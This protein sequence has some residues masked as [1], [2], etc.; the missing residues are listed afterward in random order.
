M[1][2]QILILGAH[3][4]LEEALRASTDA[5]SATVHSA[6]AL[7]ARMRRR[8]ADLVLLADTALVPRLR[9]IDPQVPIVVVAAVG[10]V[11]SAADAVA[12]GAN[13]LLVLGPKLEARV[14][15][16]RSRACQTGGYPEIFLAA[17]T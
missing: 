5:R 1:P 17:G 15:T 10:S 9:A 6:R 7:L 4:G 16:M 12:Q 14:R 3:E 2:R 13:D 8:P 11:Q